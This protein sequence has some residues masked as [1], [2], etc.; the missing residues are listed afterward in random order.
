MEKAL[1]KIENELAHSF[2]IV[3]DPAV[4][5]QIKEI[6]KMLSGKFRERRFYDNSPHV[7]I[8]TKFMPQSQTKIFDK[9]LEGEFKNDQIWKLEFSNF[10]ISDNG[11]YICLNFSKETTKKV[12]ELHKRAKRAT[13]DV[14]ALGMNGEAK[15]RYP[16]YPHLSII[17][18]KEDEAKKALKMIKKNLKGS[19]VQVQKYEITAQ[20]DD[21]T[22]FTNFQTIKRIV[23]K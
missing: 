1:E 5:N 11:T 7:S 15:P 6:Q 10:V 16:F 21:T 12:F 22:G 14:G 4:S 13:K 18:L 2:N 20:E 8:L 3:L 9:L 17:K 19:K 23:L